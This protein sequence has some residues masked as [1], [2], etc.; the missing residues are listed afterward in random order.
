MAYRGGRPANSNFRQQV[1]LS[2]TQL[3]LQWK[4]LTA[5]EIGIVP[6]TL[7][8]IKASSH[9]PAPF[10][11]SSAISLTRQFQFL[12]LRFSQ[13][14]KSS[15]HVF[16]LLF[17]LVLLFFVPALDVQH[18]AAQVILHTPCYVLLLQHH[19]NCSF[20]SD[21]FIVSRPCQY[22]LSPLSL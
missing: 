16:A 4:S 3:I 9:H 14:K 12:L 8:R 19:G 15:F 21:H 20:P 2:S 17:F 22:A 7:P 1:F 18:Q 10:G 5:V 13:Y 6:Q 11:S